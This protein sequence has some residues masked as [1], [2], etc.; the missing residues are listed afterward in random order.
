MRANASG[1][2]YFFLDSSAQSVLFLAEDLDLGDCS[3]S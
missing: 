3:A 1:T 2:F